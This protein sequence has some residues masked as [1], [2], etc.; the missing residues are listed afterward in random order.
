MSELQYTLATQERLIKEMSERLNE[1]FCKDMKIPLKIFSGD[2]FV[3]RLKLFGQYENYLE[4][5]HDYLRNFKDEQE[6]F[7]CYNRVK[8]AA[9]NYIKG[10]EAFQALNNDDMSKFASHYSF[11]ESCIYKENNIG[12]K[13]ISIDMCKANFSA[14]VEYGIMTGTE[15][16]PDYNYRMF[17]RQFTDIE[18][19]INSKYIRQVIFGNCNPKRQVTYEKYIMNL[20]LD[21]L[22]NNN[23]VEADDIQ[24]LCSDE[25]IIKADK[26]TDKQIDGI[27]YFVNA[28]S[29][30]HVALRIQYFVLGKVVGSE[31][32]IKRAY[33]CIPDDEYHNELKC[34]NPDEAPFVYRTVY[35][36]EFEDEDY[37]FIYNNQLAR[38]INTPTMRVDFGGN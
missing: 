11:R 37:I 10:S 26:L 23:I 15:F 14:L 5:C 19:I 34:V 6:Y 30:E 18:H 25:I 7:E 22:F 9:I 3:S 28:F 4:Y 24:S 17:M 32:F 35:N 31:A 8:D 29:E 2:I 38:F 16:F 33:D 21:E 1:R 12:K 13:F 20:L 27:I 36:K